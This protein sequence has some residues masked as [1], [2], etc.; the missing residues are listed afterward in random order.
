LRGGAPG[1]AKASPGTPAPPRQ[2]P[3]VATAD[4]MRA[5]GEMPR[6]LY[7]FQDAELERLVG[8]AA[9]GGQG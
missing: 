3:R 7:P 8:A 4:P 9:P 6:L 1:F 2:E 5:L